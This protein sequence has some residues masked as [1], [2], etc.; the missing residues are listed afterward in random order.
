MALLSAAIEA[1]LFTT[2]AGQLVTR[3]GLLLR[4]LWGNP[5]LCPVSVK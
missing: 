1:G 4:G 2:T 3:R 5:A